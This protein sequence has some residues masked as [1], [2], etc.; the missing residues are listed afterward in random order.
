MIPPETVCFSGHR[1]EKLPRGNYLRIMQSLLFAEIKAVYQRGARRFITGMAQGVDLWAADCVMHLRYEDPTVCLICAE[2]YP[3]HG[4]ELRGD[5]RYH[6]RAVLQSANQV[7]QVSD[8]YSPDCFRRRNDYMIG[9]SDCL[10]AMVSDMRSGTGQT[11]R[12]AQR[13]G[14]ELHVITL[15]RALEYEARKNADFF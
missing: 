2:P 15:E 12:M 13:R 7:V 3:T 1:P 8:V 14:L 10:I 4:D 5:R 6:H 11:I 9:H